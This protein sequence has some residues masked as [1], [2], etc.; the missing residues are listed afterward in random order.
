[1]IGNSE[2]QN[3]AFGKE[4]LMPQ[5]EMLE[6]ALQRKN[7]KIAVVR[8]SAIDENRVALAPHAVELLINH[9]HEVIIEKGAGEGAR[10]DD[11]MYAEVGGRI[12]ANRSEIFDADV[13][14]KV[15]P[16]SEEEL[17]MMKGK[18]LLISIFQSGKQDEEYI[19]KLI[20]KRITAIGL[21]F[22]MDRISRTY[23]FVQSMSEITGS[24]AILIAAEYLSNASNGKGEMLGGI[25][26]ISPTDVVIIGSG[27][28]AEF[29]ART[30][31][32]L[33]ATVKIFDSSI[34]NMRL[35]QEKLGVRVFTSILQPRVLAKAL[36][37]AD[38]V[39]GALEFENTSERFL[40]SED[41]IKQM[42]PHS[43]IVDLS[44]NQGG[45]FETSE[46]TCFHQPIY[47]RYGVV[48]YCV[49]NIPSRV[50]RTASY[51]ISNILGQ[52]LIKIGEAGGLNR[53]VKNDEGLRKGIYVFNGILT[54]DGIGKRFNLPSQ[55]I[56]LLMAAF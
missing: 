43:V 22:F 20:Q 36:K 16:P 19:K 34:N 42:K 10:F 52:I 53:V 12:V 4:S 14:V 56:N 7:L 25:S 9:G 44:I 55:D 17:Q 23:P 38:V 8:E 47:R 13:I 24:T 15:A 37:T 33:G 46:L 27:T 45:C 5:E 18:Q 11:L 26:G 48:H 50:S 30:A 28:A 40:V 31:L 35:V 54:N 1:M 32:G 51:A 41:T 2:S 29:A 39:I 21:E 3:V 49:P 6:V